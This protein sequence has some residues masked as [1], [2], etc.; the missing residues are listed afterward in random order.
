MKEDAMQAGN[1]FAVVVA[2]SLAIGVAAAG[3]QTPGVSDGAVKI[4]VLTD[5]AGV[6]SDLAGA[7]AVTA[8]QMADRR[9][10]REGEAP[11]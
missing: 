11:L 1:I 2:G 4:G 5:M 8:A 10:R 7:G 3:A 6:F 9:L